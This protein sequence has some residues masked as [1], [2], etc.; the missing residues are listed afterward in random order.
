MT[1]RRVPA[2]GRYPPLLE[3]AERLL[4]ASDPLDIEGW[5]RLLSEDIHLRIAN[6][7]PVIGRSLA[8]EELVKLFWMV[9][10]LGRGFCEIW[11]GDDKE[12]LLMELDLS[13]KTDTAIPIA[14]VVRM[15]EPTRLA[16]D[17]RFYFDPAPLSVKVRG[18]GGLFDGD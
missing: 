5:A 6:Q 18:N 4:R 8:T 3:L 15:V 17:I 11:P 14:I 2:R 7:P 13:L 9:N 1:R 10:A 12:T 16:R